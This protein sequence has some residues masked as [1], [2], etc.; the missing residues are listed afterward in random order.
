MILNIATIKAM[1]T[2]DQV[3]NNSNSLLHQLYKQTQNLTKLHKILLKYLPD[4]VLISSYRDGALHLSTTHSALATR[5]RYDERN[6]LAKLTRH[7]DFSDLKNIKTAVRPE[8]SPPP[9]PVSAPIPINK[10]NAR[11]LVSNAQYIQDKSLR[12]ALINL[13]NHN[14]DE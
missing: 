6:L 9:K 3:F 12:E 7:P 14:T 8:S 4:Q 11:L 13:G 2:P 10:E 1:K 5:I